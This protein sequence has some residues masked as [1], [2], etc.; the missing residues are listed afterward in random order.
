MGMNRFMPTAYDASSSNDI[1]D[2]FGSQ[3]WRE[4]YKSYRKHEESFLHR[5]LMNHY[6]EKLTSLGYKEALRDDEVGHEPLMSTEKNAPL[7]RLLF[8]SKHEL[9]V[10][11]WKKITSREPKGQRR[12]L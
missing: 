10:E 8:A 12:L 3:N 5:H 11:F 9:G 1:D 2:F 6:K 4:I 7:Y